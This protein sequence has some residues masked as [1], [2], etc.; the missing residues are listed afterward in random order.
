MLELLKEFV[1]EKDLHLYNEDVCPDA[2]SNED[3]SAEYIEK[4]QDIIK[5]QKHLIKKLCDTL[6]QLKVCFIR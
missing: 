1:D 6:Q 2:F 3:N 5:K 4:L